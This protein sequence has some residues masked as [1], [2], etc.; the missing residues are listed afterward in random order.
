MV[1]RILDVESYKW[2]PHDDV[3]T[4]Y[5]LRDSMTHYSGT[6]G[7]N[8]DVIILVGDRTHMECNKHIFSVTLE[9]KPKTLQQ[10]A[11]RIIHQY[12]TD[13]LWETLPPS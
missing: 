1:T 9:P 6:A 5:C 8:N 12:R 2:R 10:L 13:L 4:C 3:R 11:M 7:I